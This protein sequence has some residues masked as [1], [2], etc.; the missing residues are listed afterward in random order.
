M[1]RPRLLAIIAPRRF[2]EEELFVPLEHWAPCFNITIAS[3]RKGETRGMS[4][5]AFAVDTAVAETADSCFEAT[6]VLGG[7]G[8]PDFLW[9]DFAV[10]AAIRRSLAAGAV[11]AGI[12]YGVVALA[13]AGALAGRRATVYPDRRA[14][15]E[16]AR[17]GG[18][19]MTGP[20]VVDGPI[21]TARG[22]SDASLLAMTLLTLLRT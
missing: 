22:P 14:E 6:V 1:D 7:D 5:V 18:L 15:L 10:H 3:T 20:L 8:A 17:G 2:R 11:V 4:G 13:R 21:V 9:N 16:V 12:C 19:L